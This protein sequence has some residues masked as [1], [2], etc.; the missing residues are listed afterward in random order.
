L[1]LHRKAGFQVKAK[2]LNHLTRSCEILNPLSFSE[3][4]ATHKFLT[5]QERYNQLKPKH[6]LLH[7]EFLQHCLHDPTLSKEHHKA[8]AQLISL[9]SLQ[10]SYQ[11]IC[12]LHNQTAGQS[13]S[14][15]EYTLPEGNTVA[16]SKEEVERV[17]S[18]TLGS[19]FT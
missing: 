2:F 4:Q 15:V 7:Q 12:S 17:L 16:T 1:V 9:E 19:Q 13:I 5:A 10:D 3:V 8:I 18:G 6:N 14:S 11:H